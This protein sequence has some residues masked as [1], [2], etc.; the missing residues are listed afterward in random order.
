MWVLQFVRLL[1]LSVDLIKQGNLTQITLEIARKLEY[2]SLSKSFTAVLQVLGTNKYPHSNQTSGNQGANSLFLTFFLSRGG[3][4]NA[5][6]RRVLA[7]GSIST[8]ACLFWIVS[9]TVTLETLV[10]LG[11]L[12]D[13][14]PYFLRRLN[15]CMVL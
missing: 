12:R 5:C 13:V 6:M 14:L 8:S 2:K 10:P 15:T 3:S 7:L 1:L 9:F 11:T 4:F